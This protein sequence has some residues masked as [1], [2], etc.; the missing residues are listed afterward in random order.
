MQEPKNP[1]FWMSDTFDP[2]HYYGPKW[3]RLILEQISHT[4][5]HN[6]L[7][8][9]LPG[10]GKTTL[11]RYIADPRGAI[12]Q[13]LDWLQSPYDQEPN[14]LLLTLVEFRLVPRNTHPY[15]YLYNRF[16]D[17]YVSYCH[18]LDLTRTLLDQSFSVLLDA[19]AAMDLMEIAIQQLEQLGIRLVFLLD[20]FDKAFAELSTAEITRLRPWRN[21]VAL[22]LVTERSLEANSSFFQVLPILIINGL[23]QTESHQMLEQPA[24]NA[25]FTFP[26]ADL[27]TTLPYAGGHPYLLTLIGQTLWDM[28]ARIGVLNRRDLPLSESQQKMVYGRLKEKFKH[29][30]QFYKD[31]MT[32]T[33]LLTL[34][35][36]ILDGHEAL[37]SDDYSTL[38][39]LVTKGLVQYGTQDEYKVFSPLF[40]D[41][42]LESYGYTVGNGMDKLSLSLS[43]RGLNS[44]QLTKEQSR[45]LSN[46]LVAAFPREDELQRMIAFGLGTQVL[47]TIGGRT[48][49]DQ[50]FN[51]LQWAAAH[52]KVEALITAAQAANPDHTPLR[53]FAVTLGLPV[54]AATENASPA[55]PT[56]QTG[57][58]PAGTHGGITFS[59]TTNIYGPTVGGDVGNL[60]YNATP[61]ATSPSSPASSSSTLTALKRKRLQADLDSLLQQYEALAQQ[62]R[63]EL[64]GGQKVVLRQ[65][66]ES[67]EAQIT[68]IEQQ[69]G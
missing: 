60:T 59:G 48:L 62:L 25:G 47:T 20:D 17:E 13:H 41:F 43:L 3:V 52:Y 1:Y 6:L 61:P 27:E 23:S 18:H 4:P 31:K 2:Q 5:P 67:L 51:L 57:A 64:D 10:M 29:I 11:L 54:V 9:G 34:R 40:A 19:T 42:L 55:S 63:L 66:I 32:T 49:Q 12:T 53:D 58:P 35:M 46:L 69:L 21:K 8:V 14:R 26:A 16:R 50:V 33:E 28:R 7:L 24:L 56:P 30:F 65:K 44:M 22:L 39:G 37:H 15:V 36:L 68:E 38:E 45:E